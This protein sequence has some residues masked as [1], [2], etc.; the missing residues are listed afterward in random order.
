MAVWEKPTLAVFVLGK[1]IAVLGKTYFCA[2]RAGH[3]LI[4][5][6]C[7]GRSPFCIIRK[8]PRSCWEKKPLYFQENPLLFGKNLFQQSFGVGRSLVFFRIPIKPRIFCLDFPD[9]RQ[10]ANLKLASKFFLW[11]LGAHTR[12]SLTFL[13]GGVV[14]VSKSQINFNFFKYIV[15]GDVVPVLTFAIVSVEAGSL[16]KDLYRAI[17]YPAFCI[18]RFQDLHFVL[19]ICRINP[20]RLSRS[21]GLVP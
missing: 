9:P 11:V 19:I 5:G 3:Y 12:A 8:N 18:T 15:S 10:S 1:H 14:T 21:K 13:S 20:R 4:S 7:R 16:E 2:L 17:P 6:A